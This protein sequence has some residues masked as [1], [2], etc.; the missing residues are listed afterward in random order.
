VGCVNFELLQQSPDYPTFS[1]PTFRF[2]R[3][4]LSERRIADRLSHSKGLGA[5]KT[6]VVYVEL[7]REAISADGAG[8]T[9]P[10]RK[11]SRLRS[12][13]TLCSELSSGM[14]CRVK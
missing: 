5:I 2:V 4:A 12:K 14:Y 8:V 13:Y 9:L 7:Q 1:Y 3:R 10:Q 6:A 11:R